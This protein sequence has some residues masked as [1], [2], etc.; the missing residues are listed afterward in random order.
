MFYR[1]SNVDQESYSLS[2]I[3]IN[4]KQKKKCVPSFTKIS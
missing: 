1:D 4:S 2:N 3:K